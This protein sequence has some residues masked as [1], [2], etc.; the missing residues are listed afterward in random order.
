[1]RRVSLASRRIAASRRVADMTAY[2]FA[3]PS[4]D[5]R[6]DVEWVLGRHGEGTLRR[7]GGSRR[8]RA[9][10]GHPAWLPSGVLGVSRLASAASCASIAATHSSKRSCVYRLWISWLRAT[11]PYGLV[12]SSAVILRRQR[13]K[14]A[15]LGQTLCALPVY[16]FEDEVK[17]QHFCVE[18]SKGALLLAPEQCCDAHWQDA[19]FFALA[20]A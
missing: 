1:M 11:C 20:G 6:L 18:M 16:R 9:P 17:T 2:H 10:R 4:A 13:P 14:L 5:E 12:H 15:A 3:F 19:C 8:R 7:W